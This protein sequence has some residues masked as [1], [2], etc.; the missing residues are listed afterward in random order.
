MSEKLSFGKAWSKLNPHQKQHAV[1][2]ARAV[3][4]EPLKESLDGMISDL[5]TLNDLFKKNDDVFYEMR[6]TKIDRLMTEAVALGL[7]EDA[8]LTED[9]KKFLREF[10]VTKT[11]IWKVD[12]APH[13]PQPSTSTSQVVNEPEVSGCLAVK[14]SASESQVD[15]VLLLIRAFAM[16][17]VGRSPVSKF[18]GGGKLPVIAVVGLVTGA[19]YLIVGQPLQHKKEYQEINRQNRAEIDHVEK[20]TV[21]LPVWKDPFGPRPEH[22]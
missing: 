21:G 3:Y 1:K 16:Q 15:A 20:H 12:N 17:R 13:C 22:H 14:E 6:K 19:L 4:F 5:R 18:Y 11:R 7:P 2:Y 9:D 8:N 10:D